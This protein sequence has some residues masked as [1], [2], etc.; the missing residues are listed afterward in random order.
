MAGTIKT[1]ITILTLSLSLFLSGCATTGSNDTRDPLEGLNRAIFNFPLHGE[2][3]LP[4]RRGD[5][6]S[7]LEGWR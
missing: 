7:G 1:T 2:E 5:G 3:G 6:V 4:H